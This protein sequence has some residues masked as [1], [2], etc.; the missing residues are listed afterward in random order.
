MIMQHITAPPSAAHPAL[1]GT[2]LEAGNDLK[3]PFS[4]GVAVAQ[5][6]TGYAEGTYMFAT[7]WQYMHLSESEYPELKL[8][9]Y[10]NYFQNENTISTFTFWPMTI[11]QMFASDMETYGRLIQT[12]N[13]QI[14]V[15]PNKQNGG[16]I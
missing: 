12:T 11:L 7:M 2:P 13:K 14:W 3:F 15:S 16:S 9:R 4:K 10:N 8:L 1:T 6:L 5:Q